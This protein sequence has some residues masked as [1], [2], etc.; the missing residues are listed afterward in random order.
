MAAQTLR[1]IEF[2][3][4]VVYQVQYHI[5]FINVEIEN[6]I[7]L[8][9]FYFVSDAI[10]GPGSSSLAISEDRMYDTR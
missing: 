9:H 4:T 1:P 10:D 2:S 6:S 3:V 8:N 5:C 7:K